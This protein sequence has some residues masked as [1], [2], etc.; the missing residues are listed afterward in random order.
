MLAITGS[1]LARQPDECN[2]MPKKRSAKKEMR[3]KFIVYILA[4]L[5]FKTYPQ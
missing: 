5:I 3:K 1:F 4:F 2:W